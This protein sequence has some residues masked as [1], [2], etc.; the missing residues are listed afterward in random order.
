VKEVGYLHDIFF[1]SF[2]QADAI[3]F[4]KDFIR[5]KGLLLYANLLAGVVLV[6]SGIKVYLL[7]SRKN[8]AFVTLLIA[9]LLLLDGAVVVATLS[10][11]AWIGLAT[12]FFSVLFFAR[13]GT[14]A[15]MAMLAAF[16]VVNMLALALGVGDLIEKRFVDKA[17]SNEER[18]TNYRLIG[19]AVMKDPVHFM[20]GY[21]S[22]RDNWQIG[23]PVGSHS[24]PLGMMYKFGFIGVSFFTTAMLLTFIR[25]RKAIQMDRN[26]PFLGAVLLSSLVQIAVQALFIEIDVDVVYMMIWWILIGLGLSYTDLVLNRYRPQAIQQRR[27]FA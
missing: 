4:A 2:V 13:L 19:E 9:A 14:G 27:R 15:K 12:A 18:M 7:A 8:P 17:N 6:G 25:L 11:S 23:I 10:R 1:R 3:W 16:L 26:H 22:Q 20:F 24:T 5:P 21:G